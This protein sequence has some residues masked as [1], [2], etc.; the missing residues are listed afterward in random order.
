[1]CTSFI[2]TARIDDIRTLE[3]CHI[4]VTA[5]FHRRRHEDEEEKA[6]ESPDRIR[7]CDWITAYMG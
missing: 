2:T 3:D 6:Q 4:F 7:G 1:M 5:A